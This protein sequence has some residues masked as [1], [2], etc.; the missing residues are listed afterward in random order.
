[1]TGE[2]GLRF[3]LGNIAESDC[4]AIVNP[5][6][7]GFLLSHSG[8][9]GALGAAAGPAYAA[10]CAQLPERGADASVEVIVTGAGTLPA[11]YVIH[12]VSPSW[13]G[14]R[15]GEQEALRGVHERVLAIA[16][17]PRCRTLA[18]PAIGT[19]AHRFPPEVAASIAV[20]T[21]EAL[22]RNHPTLERV[23][24][25]FQTRATLHDYLVCS[26]TKDQHDLLITSLRDE[27]TSNLS[28]R[29]GLAARVDAIADETTLRAIL[30]EARVL[31]RAAG[32]DGRDNSASVGVS[33]VYVRAVERILGLDR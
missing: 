33:A 19:G 8:V 28:K 30:T 12:A 26:S 25:Y 21:V 14:G 10:E 20:P 9:N 29:D 17:G 24:F 15:S 22:L 6:N 7:R 31:S 27:I 23:S 1:M 2:R 16:S 18:L 3:L 11:R 32:A 5:C 13:S 4:D